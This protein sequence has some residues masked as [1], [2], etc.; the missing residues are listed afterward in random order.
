MDAYT[1][2]VERS[3]DRIGGSP[4]VYKTHHD[5][6]ADK[7]ID[8]VV[9]ATPDHWHKQMIIE[10]VKAGKDV[11]SEKPITYRVLRRPGDH[12]RGPRV[13]ADRPGRKPGY[14]RLDC[15]KAKEIIS[16]GKLGQVTMI[17]AAYNRNT[18]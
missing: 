4:K 5:L 9:I 11:Y 15:Q 18:A 2:R 17:R 16:S 3:L 8:T 12:R 14:Q 7:G 13:R 6:L 1:G 10:S